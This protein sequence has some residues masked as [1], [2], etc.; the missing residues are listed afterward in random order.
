MSR[1]KCIIIRSLLGLSFMVLMV[2]TTFSQSAD[3]LKNIMEPAPMHKQYSIST[4]TTSEFKIFFSGLF[5]FYKTFISSQDGSN[6]SFTPSCSVYM[7]KA[8]KKQGF[9]LGVLNGCDRLMRCNGLPTKKYKIHKE[10]QRYID[11]IQ[12]D[13]FISDTTQNHGL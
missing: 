10:K 5:V 3:K 8:V 13:P 11:P 4:A 6:C 7:K 2:S 1:I 9:L 12:N